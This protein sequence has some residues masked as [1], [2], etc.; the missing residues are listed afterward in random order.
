MNYRLTRY[1]SRLAL[2]QHT[3][4]GLRPGQWRFA[5]LEDVEPEVANRIRGSQI[6]PFHCEH[7]SPRLALFDRWVVDELGYGHENA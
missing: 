4:S 2:V 3:M 5:A 1:Y 6:D 7:G